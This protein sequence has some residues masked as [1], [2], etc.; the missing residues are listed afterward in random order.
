MRLIHGRLRTKIIVAQVHLAFLCGMVWLTVPI[1]TAQ[2]PQASA[3]QD[4]KFHNVKAS[5]ILFLGNSI[6]LHGPAPAI[7]WQGKWGMAASSQDK[8]YVHLVLMGISEVTGKQPETVVSN[9]AS[10]ERQ[11]DRY[12]IHH[13]LKKELDFKPCIVIVAIGENVP[14]LTSEQAK[15]TFQSRVTTLLKTLQENSHP[16]IVVRSC[17]WPD[18]AKDRIL[19]QGCLEVGG[20]FVDNG[21]LSKDE[22]NFARSER[23]FSHAGVAGH[24]GDRGMRAIADSILQA[25]RH[26]GSGRP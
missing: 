7:D 20:V 18:Q 25:L 16:V 15:A 14:A 12:D 22:R 6:T 23:T 8:D 24:P 13:E 1:A 4:L 5:R 9:I 21:A 2:A 26:V 17:F 3:A 11:Y 19:R 10:F